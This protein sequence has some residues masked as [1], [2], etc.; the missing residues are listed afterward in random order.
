MLSDVEALSPSADR[1][2]S[3]DCEQQRHQRRR[4][5]FVRTYLPFASFLVMAFLT[6]F[7]IDFQ[8]NNGPD[9]KSAFSIKGTIETK[10]VDETQS[11]NAIEPTA[12]S[13]SPSLEPVLSFMGL[14]A[15]PTS[16]VVEKDSSEEKET[17]NND[18][19]NAPK[20]NL[21]LHIG[22][23]KTGSTT[24]QDAWSEP[25]GVLSYPLK[26][27]NYR[28][29]FI[30]P[31]QGFFD[32]D[33]SSHGGYQNCEASSKLKGLI[34]TSKKDGQN[35]LL[36]DENLDER[37]PEAL[38]EVIDDK[39]WDVTVIV[40]YRRIHL[41]LH[42]W[43]DQIN[44]TTNKDGKGNILINEAGQPYRRE[45]TEWPGEGGVEI[46]TFSSWYKE[47]TRYWDPSELVSKHRS[48]A[49]KNAYEP[50]FNNI[51]V[52]NMHQDG[53][54][55]TNFMC[56][57]LPDAKRACGL[58]KTRNIRVPRDNQSVELD[59]DILAVK[60]RERGILK[61]GFKRKYVYSRIEKH[62]VENGKKIPRVCDMDMIDE[63]RQWLLDSEKE[64]FPEAWS[65][66]TETYLRESF[67]GYVASGKLCDIDFDHVF[68]DEEWLEFF[69]SL[70][71]RP[72]LIL[73]IGPQKTGSTTLQHAWG[74]P[75][76]LKNV[77]VQDNFHYHYINPHSGTFDCDMI[78]DRW[79]N[80]KASEKLKEILRDAR[81]NHK[82]L[83]LTDENL[84]HRFVGALREAIDDDHFR[85]KVVLVYRRIHQWLPSWYS[86]INKTANKDSSGNLLRNANG[87]P[88]RQPHTKWPADGGVRVPNFSDWYKMFVHNFPSSDLVSN[89][90]SI[91]FKETY[92]PYFDNIQV[93]DMSQDGDF[94]TNFMCQMIPEASKTC[95]RLKQGTIAIPR[96][97][98]TLNLDHDIVSVQAYEHGLIG[99]TSLS[100]PTVVEEVRKYLSKTG[101]SVP[102]VCNESLRNEI[103]DWLLDSE[104]AMF[105]MA[106]WSP[107]TSEALETNFNENYAKGKLCDVD[108]EQVLNDEDWIRFFSSLGERE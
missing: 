22:P 29:R 86:Q 63:I 102:K 36:S 101:L 49:F 13:P 50:Y 9:S 75:Q 73:H 1:T 83:V 65:E 21:V 104:K 89:H 99:N 56:D 74:A 37:F 62:V 14:T 54:L 18:A 100:R 82:N 40:M 51:L 33:V 93:Y 27:D 11:T 34:R 106:S 42:S 72:R 47:F 23:Q 81:Q 10:I 30:H 70:D 31:D 94:V 39:D 44:K 55:I 59:Y 108:V 52:H 66:D 88:E 7:Y 19:G 28:Y 78:G 58:L 43:Y 57:S 38:R 53:D 96:E 15:K 60:A 76:E 6:Y 103:H 25:F 12:P 87:Q 8:S 64:M 32:C 26:M 61:T 84:D 68:A 91:Y 90:P 41:W 77:M 105:P 16:N 5:R 97:N 69:Q 45:H 92:E 95:Q 20:Q 98:P 46:P 71:G 24:L 79:D 85:V 3:T 48:I 2:G 35:L 80:C 67:E 4:G 17:N 107:T